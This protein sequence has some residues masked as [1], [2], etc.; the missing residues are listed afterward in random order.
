MKK[1]NGVILNT[2]P[3]DIKQYEKVQKIGKGSFGIVI[4]QN[5][6]NKRYGLQEY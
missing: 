3:T 6:K 4:F 5:N 2:F 1:S